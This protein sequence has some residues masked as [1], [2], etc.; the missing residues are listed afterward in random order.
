MPRTSLRTPYPAVPPEVELVGKKILDAAF[1]VHTALG[2]GLL[3]SVYEACLAYEIRK[4]G[5]KVDTQIFLPV[6]YEGVQ[7]DAG[8]R[9][10]MYVER[11]VIVEIKSVEKMNPVYEA[12]LITYLKLTHTRLGYLINFNVPHLRDGFKR[13]VL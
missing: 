9:M 2:A 3:E 5:L 11:C 10:D 13:L 1:R 8:L 6:S 4:S 12:Q 7:V